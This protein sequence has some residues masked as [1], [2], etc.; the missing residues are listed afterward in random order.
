MTGYK[1]KTMMCSPIKDQHGS[2]IGV[3]Q[4]KIRK[5]S[6][7]NLLFLNFWKVLIFVMTGLY[8]VNILRLSTKTMIATSVS[9]TVMCLKDICS[10]VAWVWGTLRFMSG[11]CWR[12]KGTRFSS[13]LLVS[14]SKSRVHWTSWYS[15]SSRTSSHLF[16]V[17][18]LWFF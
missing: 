15:G 8:R 17:I 2:V 7:R 12:S 14:S 18:E 10:S 13:T 16:N 11:V 4:V 1:T 6:L 5:Y 9:T 3:A